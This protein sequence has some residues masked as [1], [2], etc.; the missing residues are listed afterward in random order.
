MNKKKCSICGDEAK[1]HGT[2]QESGWANFSYYGSRMIEKGKHYYFCLPHVSN[3]GIPQCIEE[4]NK[5]PYNY[6][7]IWLSD[8]AIW[9]AI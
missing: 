2:A 6:K 8:I 9:F 4:Y 3:V 5:D 1:Y 7:G